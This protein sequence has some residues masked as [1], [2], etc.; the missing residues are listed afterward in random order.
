MI[1]FFLLNMWLTMQEMPN[2]KTQLFESIKDSRTL[3]HGCTWKLN[4][5]DEH[6][7]Y[8]FQVEAN[9]VERWR[10]VRQEDHRNLFVRK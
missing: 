10:A 4:K 6:K 5:T 1:I 9:F 8:G 2:L 7:L 3:K